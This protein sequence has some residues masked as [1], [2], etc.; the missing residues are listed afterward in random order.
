MQ[1][2]PPPVTMSVGRDYRT[3]SQYEFVLFRGEEVIARAGFFAS[4]A[5][6]RRE[7]RRAA[8]PFLD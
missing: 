2:I 7:G 1:A 5:K 4:A 6:A 8:E 3:A